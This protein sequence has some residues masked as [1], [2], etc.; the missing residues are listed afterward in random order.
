MKVFAAASVTSKRKL[1]VDVMVLADV[2]VPWIA[3]A[4]EIQVIVLG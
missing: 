3:V 1:P 4:A 2:Q